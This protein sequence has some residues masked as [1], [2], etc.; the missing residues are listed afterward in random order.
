VFIVAVGLAIRFFPRM[1]EQE[2][3]SA[4]KQ[5]Q[6]MTLQD[7]LEQATFGGGCFWC[8]EAIFR[9]LKGVHSVVSGYSGGH[10]SNPS[11]E[12]VCEGTTGH[13][14]VIQITFDPKVISFVAL[15]EVFWRTHD[16]TTRNRQGN[17][18]G[19]QYRSV[20]FYHNDEQK[21]VAQE[22][23]AELDASGVFEKPI[24]TEI[25]PFAAFYRAEGYHQNY[26]ERNP[27]QPYCFMLIRP[28]L[29]KFRK[30]F[31]D[32]LKGEVSSTQ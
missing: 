18:V 26:Y 12:E 32:K 2:T 22:L 5:E 4:A 24:V 27:K 17:D 23:M 30:I 6:L 9:E 1:H 11:Y 8:T 10:V 29:A 15:L 3:V 20:V 31:Q 21:R 28:K 19:P 25:A 13:A 16:P 7:E 14:E